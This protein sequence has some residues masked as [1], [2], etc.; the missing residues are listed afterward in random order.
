MSDVVP[1]GGGDPTPETGQVTEDQMNEAMAGIMGPSELAGG[2]EDYPDAILTE[3]F[4]WVRILPPTVGASFD[5]KQFYNKAVQHHIS[6][7]VSSRSSIL[8]RL[9]DSGFYT[10]AEEQSIRRMGQEMDGL[11]RALADAQLKQN[12]EA[13]KEVE[14]KIADLQA[15]IDFINVPLQEELDCSAEALAESDRW[16][17]VATRCISYKKDDIEKG[18]TAGMPVW[19]SVQAL[20][21]EVQDVSVNEILEAFN[22]VRAGYPLK[23]S[24]LSPEEP[25]QPAEGG[26]TSGE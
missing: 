24:A 18:I 6:S 13:A 1:A 10:V 7:G 2:E 23:P 3:R 26:G 16:L 11:N 25:E 22:R 8:K 20:R 15:K 14:G 4:G 21:E 12:E 17:F 5:S 19:P 9:N